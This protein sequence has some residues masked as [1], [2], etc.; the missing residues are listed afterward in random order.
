MSMGY[1]VTVSGS[2]TTEVPSLHCT[3]ITL[4]L[5]NGLNVYELTDLEMAWT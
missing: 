5:R 2:L 4:S 3:L 1:G